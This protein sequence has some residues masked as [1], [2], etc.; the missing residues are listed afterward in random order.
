MHIPKVPSSSDVIPWTLGSI[1]GGTLYSPPMEPPRVPNLTFHHQRRETEPKNLFFPFCSSSSNWSSLP[2]KP[3]AQA[4]TRLPFRLHG[5][6]PLRITLPSFLYRL[7]SFDST[8]YPS[9]QLF[10][11]YFFLLQPLL[12]ASVLLHRLLETRP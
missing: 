11:L 7:A 4:T 10:T 6:L 5:A 2:R 9:A 8:G 12:G 3:T 1:F